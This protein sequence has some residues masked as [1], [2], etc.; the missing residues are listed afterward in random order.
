MTALI[1]LHDWL[2]AFAVVSA[3]D[4][5]E[6]P[7]ADLQAGLIPPLPLPFNELP[8]FNLKYFIPIL[9]TYKNLQYFKGRNK[10]HINMV[11]FVLKKSSE[12]L[13]KNRR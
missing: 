7:L 9:S 13:Y 10:K 6:W 1:F 12:M 4:C 5:R 11:D 3:T 8:S 2:A